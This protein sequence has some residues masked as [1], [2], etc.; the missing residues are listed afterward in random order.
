MS[1]SPELQR[2]KGLLRPVQDFPIPG[3]LFQDI[4]PIFQDPTATKSLVD[5]LVE[6][7]RS[8]GKV[9]VIVGLDSRGFLLGPWI[10]SILGIAFAPVRKA[11]KLPPP[12]HSVSYS[13]EYGSDSFD[14][15]ELAIK[16]GQNVV[17][18]DDLIATGG[19]AGAAGD[20]I[21]L[22]G[23]NTVQYVFL[24]ELTGLKGT[25]K[26][27]APAYSVFQFDD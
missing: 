24:I 26:L 5:H 12:V 7:I 16:Q 9:D 3:I 6:H 4:F 25:A 2:I 15:S 17:V 21:K 1:L 13:L 11:G 18:L 27:N 20:L 23:G 14:I 22:C 8:L 10:A 19:S